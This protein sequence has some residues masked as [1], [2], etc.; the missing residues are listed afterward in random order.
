MSNETQYRPPPPPGRPDVKPTE[1][2][3]PAPSPAEHNAAV[4]QARAD[5]NLPR[6]W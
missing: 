2:R 3:D 1:H 4:Q 6:A 5:G